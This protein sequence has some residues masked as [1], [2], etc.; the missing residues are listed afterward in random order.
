MTNEE[1]DDH[2]KE[3]VS[4]IE[5]SVHFRRNVCSGM[6]GIVTALFE[7][8]KRLPEEPKPKGN[9]HKPGPLSPDVFQVFTGDKNK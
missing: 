4:K 9:R 5:S 7:I 2:L 6:I 8:A 3:T 1:I